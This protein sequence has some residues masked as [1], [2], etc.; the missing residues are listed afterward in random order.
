MSNIVHNDFKPS[1]EPESRKRLEMKNSS[2]GVLKFHT[3]SNGGLNITVTQGGKDEAYFTVTPEDENE[4]LV[5]LEN[6]F[7]GAK[8]WK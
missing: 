2:G 1:T 7:D 5:S 3:C 6:I 8:A 4:F